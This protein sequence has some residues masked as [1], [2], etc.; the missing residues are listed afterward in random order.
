MLGRGGGWGWVGVRYDLMINAELHGVFGMGMYCGCEKIVPFAGL[1]MYD[2]NP[3][4][5]SLFAVYLTWLW[6]FR[7]VISTLYAPL[8]ISLQ[9]HVS[10]I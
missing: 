3:L 7:N 5:K 8:D 10:S 9:I 2:I 6:P 1:F 4:V